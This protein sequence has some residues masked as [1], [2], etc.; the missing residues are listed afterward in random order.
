MAIAVAWLVKIF[1]WRGVD[2]TAMPDLLDATGLKGN[3]NEMHAFD[4][5]HTERNYLQKEMG[6]RV[7][8]KHREILRR[9]AWSGGGVLPILL[10]LVGGWAGGILAFVFALFAALL[11][12]AGTIL[13]R[14][15]FFAEAVHVS[16]LYYDEK[17]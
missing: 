7:G 10:L 1:Y 3:W 12:M 14:W 15:L 5:P 9:M 17:E 4:L 13:S 2:A 11:L 16:S 8:R 6:Y